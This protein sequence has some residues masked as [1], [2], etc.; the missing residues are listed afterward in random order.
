MDEKKWVLLKA[1]CAEKF[2]AIMGYR[3]P[4]R[5]SETANVYTTTEPAVYIKKDNMLT[6]KVSEKEANIYR[7][8]L[9]FREMVKLNFS[10][11]DYLNNVLLSMSTGKGALPPIFHAVENAYATSVADMF[12]GG[13]VLKSVLMTTKREYH[14]SPDID[15]IELPFFSFL[16]AL[17]QYCD[18][19]VLKGD[20]KDEDAE[21]A[22]VESL[23][24]ID[25]ALANADPD[26]RIDCYKKIV[27]ISK[28][29]WEPFDE[30]LSRYMHDA[31]SDGEDKSGI[32]AFGSGTG[33]GEESEPSEPD[34]SKGLKRRTTWKKFEK[35]EE[36]ED[37]ASTR[38]EDKPLSHEA[39]DISEFSYTDEDIDFSS[40]DEFEAEWD[41]NVAECG[42][43][44][45]DLIKSEL[46][47]EEK[48][49][50]SA[51]PPEPV[52]PLPSVAAKYEGKNYKC[53]NII[54]KLKDPLMAIN[55]YYSTIGKFNKQIKTMVGKLKSLF[56]E[57]VEEKEYKESGKISFK[58]I[59]SGTVSSKVFT[60]KVEPGGR[61]SIAI[62]MCIDESGSMY[63]TRIDRAKACAIALSEVFSQMDL[64]FYVIGFTADTDGA[65]VLHRHYLQWSGKNIA[66]K[67][68]LTTIQAQANN[69]DGYSIRCASEILAKRPE[70]HKILIVISDGQP[71]ANAYSYRSGVSGVVDT[72]NAI[73]EACDSGQN[74]VGV[75]IGSD[76]EMLSK[77][78]KDDFVNIEK[79][80]DLFIGVSRKFTDMVKRW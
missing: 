37:K 31:H 56:A 45:E 53:K 26:Q 75:A 77:M 34:R 32:F 47:I 21:E 76:K 30:M 72:S 74:V 51:T 38:S 6:D 80:D 60:K 10:D 48:S 62:M 65:D 25:E 24:I 18:E 55:D 14:V 19:G 40:D 33:S 61:S 9:F 78:Y 73:R 68:A 54:V 20:F 63:G 59:T 15:S 43:Y 12:I 64:P 50:V 35:K 2:N 23:P 42:E 39:H 46:E 58:K 7:A 67:A 70:E 41:E 29:L 49:K 66:D 27:D 71:A 11:Y 5:D 17:I 3:V 57:D 28:K 69:F 79:L 16:M 52:P 36:E 1:S 4:I 44:F 13:L 8:G 22:F